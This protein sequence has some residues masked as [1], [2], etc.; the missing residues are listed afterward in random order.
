VTNIEKKR[1]KAE[2]VKSSI[3]QRYNDVYKYCMPH[4]GSAYEFKDTNGAYQ[5]IDVGLFNSIG[6]NAA[7]QF[8]NR[9]QNLLCPVNSNFIKFEVGP[10][11]NKVTKQDRINYAK[12]L[13]LLG[14]QLNL[15]KNNSNFDMA[16]SEFFF[17]LVAG[18]ACL[19]IQPLNTDT[20]LNFKCIPFR[21]YA[22]TEGN[23]GS[24]DG[25]YRKF[26]L[27]LEEV[28]GTW[29]DC[30]KEGLESLKEKFKGNLNKD[31]QITLYEAT[32]YDYKEK[33]YIYVVYEETS[34]TILVNRIYKN[35][36]FLVLRWNKSSDDWYGIGVGMLAKN[37]LA[38]YNEIMKDS[39]RALAFQLP[40]FLSDRDDILRDNFLIEPGAVNPVKFENGK[41]L[42]QVMEFN[43]RYDITQF[44]IDQLKMEVN[45]TML[46]GVIPDDSNVRTASEINIRQA[47]QSTNFINVFGRFLSEFLYKLPLVMIEI[48]QK[49]FNLLSFIKLDLF[50]NYRI[51]TLTS[52]PISRVVK[53]QEI[54]LVK[55][56]LQFLYSLDPT[57]IKAEQVYNVDE[58]IKYC[59]V[60]RNEFI[61][62]AE[63]TENIK[64][65]QQQAQQQQAQQQADADA[66][67]AER[68]AVAQQQAKANPENN[69]LKNNLGF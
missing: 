24:V 7:V 52:S 23:D 47:E 48:L 22:I 18:T 63:E 42:M 39:L 36:P 45:K 46:A 31:E 64:L 28:K 11:F 6:Q 8:V 49:N 25:I 50:D 30:E 33:Y 19:L 54:N 62:T 44:N 34:K 21:Q 17:D 29:T 2:N 13:E 41:P 12:Q 58:A 1:Q 51:L 14:D 61:K 37:D 38:T 69:A 40:I 4:R 60:G 16:I 66:M 55:E 20:L 3:Q 10:G 27:K 56:D 35:N 9:M 53:E 57:G 67:V 5:K 43:G 59:L 15:I 65:Q 32:Y 26:I 68:K